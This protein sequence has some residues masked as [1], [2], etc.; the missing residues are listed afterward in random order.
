MK[1]AL[2]HVI[3]RG[4]PGDACWS[5]GHMKHAPHDPDLGMSYLAAIQIA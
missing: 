1:L 5:P 3:S 4:E 2:V